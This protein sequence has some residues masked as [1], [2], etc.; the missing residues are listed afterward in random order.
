MHFCTLYYNIR[1]LT[2]STEASKSESS[3]GLMIGI[4]AIALVVGVVFGVVAT[5]VVMK[6]R[7]KQ[8]GQGGAAAPPAEEVPVAVS[9]V[10]P[11]ASQPFIP[12]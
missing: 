8:P 10:A 11:T 9:S 4:V 3:P 6:K 5:V 12:L 7:T 2:D 1:S